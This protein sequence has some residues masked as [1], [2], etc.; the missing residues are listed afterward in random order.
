MAEEEKTT[1]ELIDQLKQKLWGGKCRQLALFFG[2]SG[3]VMYEHWHLAPA[4]VIWTLAVLTM[5]SSFGNPPKS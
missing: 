2:L 4:V 1:D 5:L 3:W